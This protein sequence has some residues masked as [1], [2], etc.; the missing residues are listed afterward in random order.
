MQQDESAHH[1]GLGERRI[2]ADG[3]LELRRRLLQPAREPE[4]LPQPE[5]R[6]QIVGPQLDR[7]GVTLD[8]LGMPPAHAQEHA[9]PEL[10]LLEVRRDAQRRLELP[11]GTLGV[12]AHHQGG[13]EPMPQRR[14][15]RGLAQ[16]LPEDRGRPVE[17][18]RIHRPHAPD[19]VG[20]GASEQ[21]VVGLHEGVGGRRHPVA[22]PLEVGLRPG[23]IP[24]GPVGHGQ[25]VVQASRRG[26]EGQG[27]LQVA[28]G[29]L[30]VARRE[31]RPPGAGQGGRGGRIDV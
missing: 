12:P 5:P 21:T 24:E 15:V 26:R 16:P 14:I 11:N 2:D 29:P 22:A 25:V 1:P 27:T 3:L 4:R 17:P 6:L 9:D 10:R 8:R 7:R 20:K 28:H 13:S 19:L 18:P 31:R 23:E 30:R